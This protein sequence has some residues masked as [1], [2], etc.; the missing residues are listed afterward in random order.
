MIGSILALAAVAL[1]TMAILA[2]SRMAPEQRPQLF[3]TRTTFAAP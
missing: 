2:D 3:Q 1:L